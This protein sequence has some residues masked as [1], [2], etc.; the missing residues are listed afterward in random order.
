MFRNT[1]ILATVD[2]ASQQGM[3]CGKTEQSFH[4]GHSMVLLLLMDILVLICSFVFCCKDE[5]EMKPFFPYMYSKESHVINSRFLHMN[6]I[7]SL[8]LGFFESLEQER[9]GFSK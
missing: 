5:S 4:I 1:V 2:V 7:S 3:E 8:K 9:E 6:V